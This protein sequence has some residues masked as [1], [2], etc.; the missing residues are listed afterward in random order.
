MLIGV[1]LTTA[2]AI[3]HAAPLVAPGALLALVGGGWLGNALARGDVRVLPGR[4]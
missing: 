1:G 2:G 4:S 3:V